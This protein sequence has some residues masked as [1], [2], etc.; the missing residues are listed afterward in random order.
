M[1]RPP[2]IVSWIANGLSSSLDTFFLG[3]FE[4]KRAE[5]WQTLYSTVSM[6]AP[7]VIFCSEDDPAPIQI[8]CN[9]VQRLK[10]LGAD[11]K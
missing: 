7:Y 5:Y 9:F 4:S 2:L 6:G 10:D 1:S 3:R 8:I 11:V